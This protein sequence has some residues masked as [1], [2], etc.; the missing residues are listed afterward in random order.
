[1]AGLLDNVARLAPPG[2]VSGD[3]NLP[4][5]TAYLSCNPAITEPLFIDRKSFLFSKDFRKLPEFVCFG[6]LVRKPTKSGSTVACMT[7]V[8]CVDP[9]WL[10][11][12]GEDSPLLS[13]GEPLDTPL[14]TYDT[15]KEAVMCSIA[16]KYGYLGWCVPPV[17]RV[18]YEVLENGKIHSSSF[19]KDD[20]FRWFARF[21]LEGKV[22]EGLCNLPTML[23]D[24]PAIITRRKPAGKVVS[25]VSALAYAG[26]DSGRALR[27]YW[28]EKDNKFLLRELK[29]WA[30]K[31]SAEE[32]KQL[33][34]SAVKE[35]VHKWRN[36]AA[37]E[38]NR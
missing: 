33:W 12:L 27:K 7:Y 18:M 20:S 4:L 11:I 8:T 14:P 35:S 15:Q 28:A 10:G 22:V 32:V 30:K 3:L 2:S 1:M 16:T 9:S 25:L 34:I 23:N 29:A 17:R 21:M 31:E 36:E 38:E 13:L 6:S 5:R 24:A 26:V 37:G 19:M